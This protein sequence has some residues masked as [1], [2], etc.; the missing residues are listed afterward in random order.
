MYIKA[1]KRLERSAGWKYSTQRFLINR[2][3][4]ISALKKSVDSGT[5]KPGK[6][7]EFRIRENGHE[8]VIQAM[9][10]ADS[11]LQADEI[12]IPRLQHYLIYDNG[13]SIKGKGISF[14]RRRFEE[15]LHWHYRRY[16]TKG[17]VLMI[18]FRK[19]FDNIRHDVVMQMI[20]SKIHDPD[21]LKL[22][23]KVF[24]TYKVDVSY[25]AD[26]D[27][28]DHVFNSLEYQKIPDRLKTGKR[29][30]AKSIGI[31]S[32]IRQIIG[33]FY[34]TPIDNYC[35]TVCG[36]HCYDAYMD[37]RIIIHPS[38]GYLKELLKE[39]TKIAGQLGIH[40]NNRKTQIIKLSHGFTWLKTRYILTGSGKIIRKIPRDCVTRERRKLKALAR[41]AREDEISWG[42]VR[43]QYNAWRGDKKW[44]N[45]YHTLL[46]MDKLYREV[47]N[48]EQKRTKHGVG[49]TDHK[50]ARKAHGKYQRNWRLENRKNI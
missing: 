42:V 19:Y 29:Y 16:G 34:P 31:G 20:A 36:L 14:T 8:R 49:S 11:V 38:K 44:Y 30:M 45:A 15:H 5:Y 47:T 41:M 26:P 28:I 43:E 40:I 21:V 10:P 27:I 6:G 3:S 2:L 4:E 12:L 9:R 35:K 50:P 37:D 18:D 46:R 17:Y 23:Q 13:A 48:D 7:T 1:S 24:D 25:S 32:Q 33:V 22:A 39:I